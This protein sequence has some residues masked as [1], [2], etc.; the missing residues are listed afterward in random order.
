MQGKSLRKIVVKVASDTLAFTF[1]HRDELAGQ[2]TQFGFAPSQ[3]LPHRFS[4]RNGKS[5]TISPPSN[6]S[7]LYIREMPNPC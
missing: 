7:A 5:A 2:P 1:L 3:F 4:L 6:C